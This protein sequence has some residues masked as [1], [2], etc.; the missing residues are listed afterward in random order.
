MTYLLD[1]LTIAYHETETRGLLRRSGLTLT[2]VL[3]G[4]LLLGT[5]I[6]VAGIMSRTLAEA[7][8]P[9]HTVARLLV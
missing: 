2:F 8:D 4:A 6:A 7:P 5:V 3:G 1:A 9:V